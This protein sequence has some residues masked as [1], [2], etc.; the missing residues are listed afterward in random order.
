MKT[1]KTL[2]EAEAEL[3]KIKSET[4]STLLS[5][6]CDKKIQYLVIA[7]LWSFDAE[8]AN[9]KERKQ[10]ISQ[11]V[12]VDAEDVKK[13]NDEMEKF[14]KLSRNDR[15]A[16]IR[17]MSKVNFDSFTTR[18]EKNSFGTNFRIEKI[19]FA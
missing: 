17:S 19:S 13:R 16:H 10:V 12:I 4:G 14:R 11:L 5:I 9:R 1:F 6:V 3:K 7:D 2:A 15:M 8:I 18:F